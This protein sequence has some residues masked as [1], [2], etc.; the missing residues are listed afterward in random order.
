MKRQSLGDHPRP[1]PQPIATL[2]LVD[3]AAKSGAKT[4]RGDHSMTTTEGLRRLSRILPSAKLKLVSSAAEIMQDRP[5]Y[6]DKAFAPRILVTTTFPHRQPKGNPEAVTRRNGRASLTIRPG[7]DAKNNKRM[8][9]PAGA[10]PRLLVVYLCREAKRADA[11]RDTSGRIE[12]GHSLRA[13]MLELGLNPA[14]GSS[15]AKRSD[16]A[17]LRQGMTAFLKAIVS[18]EEE[19]SR[20][21]A[22]GVR[23]QAVQIADAHELW[24]SDTDPDHPTLWGSFVQLHPTFRA[25]L[26]ASVI[27]TD[28]R[29][30]RALKSSVMALDFYLWLCH[31]AD[32][33]HRSGKERFVSWQCLMEQFGTG[34]TNPKR[35]G[36]E[37]RAALRKVQVVFPQLKLGS[38]R[39]GVT[40]LPT[41]RQ[42]IAPRPIPA[43]AHQ[44]VTIDN[45]SGNLL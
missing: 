7:W 30:L 25:A 28:M 31:E 44:P 17:R 37:A 16:A 41:S 21:D 12:L 9:Y 35:F 3:D 43:I 4:F 18:Y 1:T 26:V 19:L 36:E 40:I 13:F 23:F 5:S 39:G 33:A 10:I 11:N 14:N 42:A 20:P 45:A 6:D 24:W 32:R 34:W 29:A 38:L 27:P 15:R 8:P 22:Q 2:P